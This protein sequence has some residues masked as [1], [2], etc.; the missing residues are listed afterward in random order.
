[1]RVAEVYTPVTYCARARLWCAAGR[2]GP[3]RPYAVA[4]RAVLMPGALP[5]CLRVK[6]FKRSYFLRVAQTTF[7]QEILNTL[8]LLGDCAPPGISSVERHGL[9]EAHE[10]FRGDAVRLR[11]MNLVSNT[12][13]FE[14]EFQRSSGANQRKIGAS[15]RHQIDTHREAV[16][17]LIAASTRRAA[18]SPS[19]KVGKP[20]RSSP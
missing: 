1:M 3:C 16:E 15:C 5:D 2:P 12:D 9:R 19:S 8:L 20:S 11:G 17:D 18:R 7:D 6:A 4:C 13:R 10:G 14:V